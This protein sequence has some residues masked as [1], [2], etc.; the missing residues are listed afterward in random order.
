MICMPGFATNEDKFLAVFDLIQLKIY[1][2]F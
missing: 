1:L 2:R